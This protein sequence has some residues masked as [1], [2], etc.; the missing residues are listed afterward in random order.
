MKFYFY[1][2]PLQNLAPGSSWTSEVPDIR[3]L[4]REGAEWTFCIM[5]DYSGEGQRAHTNTHMAQHASIF[6]NTHAHRWFF[7]CCFLVCFSCLTFCLYFTLYFLSC[8]VICI[9]SHVINRI[10]TIIFTATFFWNIFF[11]LVILVIQEL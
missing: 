7:C 4:S 3:L 1:L 2:T 9:Y 8:C 5:G 11:S 10:Y 6:Q